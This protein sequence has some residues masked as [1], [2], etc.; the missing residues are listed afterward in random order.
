M[1]CEFHTVT[2]EKEGPIE[3]PSVNNSLIYTFWNSS[4]TI[5]YAFSEKRQTI[6]SDAYYYSLTHDVE[7][8]RPHFERTAY[9]CKPI[10]LP[11]NT[12]PRTTIQAIFFILNLIFSTTQRIGRYGFNQ[13]LLRFFFATLLVEKLLMMPKCV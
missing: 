2:F 10:P 13:C 1:W 8:Y 3:R 11:D 7:K 9:N 6:T 12:S 5:R 4:G